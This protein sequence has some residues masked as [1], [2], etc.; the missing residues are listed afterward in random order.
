M[1]IYV[2][3]FVDDLD[4]S[5]PDVVFD[6]LPPELEDPELTLE[7]AMSDATKDGLRAQTERA[8]SRGLF[9]AP[10]LTV[11]R[12]LFWGGDRVEQA[13]RFAGASVG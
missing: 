8:Q 4:I 1:A 6:C 10:S 7:D 9:G 11:D 3:N 2:A 5:M 12:E 13:L